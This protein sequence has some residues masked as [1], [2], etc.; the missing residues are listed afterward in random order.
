MK[1]SK[2]AL[3]L[4]VN[5]ETVLHLRLIQDV[6]LLGLRGGA[7]KWPSDPDCYTG[8][9]SKIASCLGS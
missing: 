2:I 6:E 7:V 9:L 5:A 4:R 8:E 1:K 3:K